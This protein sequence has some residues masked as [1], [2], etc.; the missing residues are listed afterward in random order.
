MRAR[1][2]SAQRWTSSASRT[3]YVI[4]APPL[5]PW[6]RASGVRTVYPARSR[7][8]ACAIMPSRVSPTPCNSITPAPFRCEGVNSH[9]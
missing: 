1:I 3:P 9:P 2:Q 5:D 4:V 7:K 8:S 6:P